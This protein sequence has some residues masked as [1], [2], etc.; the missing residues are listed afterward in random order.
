MGMEY[1]EQEAKYYHDIGGLIII[2]AMTSF[3]SAMLG[4]NFQT[5]GGLGLIGFL[6]YAI[7]FYMHKNPQTKKK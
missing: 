4:D 2:L 7:G 3:T 5:I 6:V 1:S